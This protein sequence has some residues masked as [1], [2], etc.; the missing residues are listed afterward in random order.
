MTPSLLIRL[1]NYTFII[2]VLF[3]H[4]FMLKINWN[5][6]ASLILSSSAIQKCSKA[7]RTQE[8]DCSVNPIGPGDFYNPGYF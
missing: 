6:D 3:I 8:L 1:A 2:S 5:L 7:Y 4:D